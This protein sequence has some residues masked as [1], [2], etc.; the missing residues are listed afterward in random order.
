MA[1]T[2]NCFNMKDVI[3]N[4][5]GFIVVFAGICITYYMVNRYICIYAVTSSHVEKVYHKELVN[6][7][8]SILDSKA[9]A[10]DTLF[11]KRYYF[12]YIIK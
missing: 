12:D 2:R 4:I 3:S 1:T 11:S 10:N 7:I 6:T 9:N 5:L 8:D